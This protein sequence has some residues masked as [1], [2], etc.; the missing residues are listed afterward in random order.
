MKRIVSAGAAFNSQLQKYGTYMRGRQKYSIYENNPDNVIDYKAQIT[1]IHPYDEAEYAWARIGYR[2]AMSVEFIRDGEVIDK[3]QLHYYEP[4]DY[5]SEDE[6]L[7]DVID[8]VCVEL[9]A[10][11]K[12]IEPKMIHN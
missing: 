1:E 12:G 3:M 10:I 4:D 8:Q 9:R 2:G 6:Y 7:D 11:N 5:E